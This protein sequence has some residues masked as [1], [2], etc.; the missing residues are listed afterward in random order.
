M[1]FIYLSFLLTVFGCSSSSNQGASSSQKETSSSKLPIE[2]RAEDVITK[3]NGEGYVN[4]TPAQI[5]IRDIIQQLKPSGSPQKL[6]TAADMVSLFPKESQGFPLIEESGN[7]DSTFGNEGTFTKLIYRKD[8]QI[9]RISF[10]DTGG[11]PRMIQILAPWTIAPSHTDKEHYYEWTRTFGGFPAHEKWKK[12]DS[13]GNF[14]FLIDNRWVVSIHS[15]NIPMDVIHKIGGALN[16]AK[17]RGL[18]KK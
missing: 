7:K 10:A 16:L 11:D 15:K 17:L 3:K 9:A 4:L 8:K 2:F 5:E 12:K 1:K 13:D 18:A 14:D 6:L